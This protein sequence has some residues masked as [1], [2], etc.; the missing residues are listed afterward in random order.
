MAAAAG[1]I[2]L[3]AGGC[4]SG[5]GTAPAPSSG[6]VYQRLVAGYVAY[7]SCARAHGMPNLPDPQVDDQGNDH[8]PALDATGHWRWPQSVLSGCASVWNRVHA[9]RD[10]F[11][12]AHLQKASPIDF[13][14][15]QAMV[16][17]IRRHGFPNF[18]D[19][20]ANGAFNAAPP[21]FSKPNLSPQA[22]AALD[23]CRAR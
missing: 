22:R 1:T 15:A 4:G 18:P 14:K 12:N 17:C 13:H 6:A 20:A 2:A 7:A 8:F 3:L 21:G 19:P 23:A 16:R 10:Q 9:I 5:G 11:D